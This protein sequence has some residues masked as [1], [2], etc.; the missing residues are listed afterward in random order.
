MGQVSL[1]LS[2]FIKENEMVRNSMCIKKENVSS[3]N[4][5]QNRW[6]WL[7]NNVITAD[8]LHRCVEHCSLSEAIRFLFKIRKEYSTVTA[9]L[10]VFYSSYFPATC[11]WWKLHDRYKTPETKTA[12]VNVNQTSLYPKCQDIDKY[13]F[14]VFS[15]TKNRRN[16]CIITKKCTNK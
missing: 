12:S 11:Q 2:L 1:C 3:Y 14:V 13:M 10:E 16:W 4:K 9:H 8:V 15:Q 6:G 7:V 5:F